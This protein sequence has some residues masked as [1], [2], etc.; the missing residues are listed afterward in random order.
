MN[1]VVG[2]ISNRPRALGE[3]TYG[4]VHS[5]SY[6]SC[7][8]IQNP[9]IEFKADQRVF[10][11]IKIPGQMAGEILIWQGAARI[12]EKIICSTPTDVQIVDLP[13]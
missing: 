5:N 11:N 13:V 4:C 2:A 3:R 1:A 12:L 10:K 9:E 8:I 6:F 7:L